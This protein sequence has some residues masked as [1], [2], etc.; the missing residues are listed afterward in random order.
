MN[1]IINDSM[2]FALPLFIIAIGGIY[3]EG[4]GVIN[5]ALEGLL[6][7]GAFFG[8]LSFAMIS[9][10]LGTT[11]NSMIYLSLIFSMIGGGLFAILYALLAIRFKANQVISGVVINMLSVSLTAFLANQLNYSLFGQASNKFMLAVFPRVTVPFLNKVPVIGAFFNETYVF[12]YIIIA[13]ALIMWFVLYKTPY[14]MSVRACGDNPQAVATAGRDVNKIRFSAV[15][16]SGIMAGIGGMCFAY[17]ISTNFSPSIYV[18]YGYL[19]IAAYIFGNYKIGQTLLACLIFGFARTFG[20]L[21]VQALALPSTY[22]DLALTF[23]YIVT[24]V[25]LIFFSKN[26]TAPKGLGEVYEKSKR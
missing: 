19:A 15:I 4:S 16:I 6:G 20:Y 3:C 18:G 9:T 5:L 17:S 7:V 1:S 10:Q 8:G 12:E 14:G 26:F 11:T 24:L 2:A 21:I 22:S 23:P 25:L 13:I